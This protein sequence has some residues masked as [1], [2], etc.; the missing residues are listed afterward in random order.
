MVPE[1]PFSDSSQCGSAL[2][3]ASLDAASKVDPTKIEIQV[4]QAASGET[5]QVEFK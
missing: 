3:L 4:P 2:V 1:S 5:P